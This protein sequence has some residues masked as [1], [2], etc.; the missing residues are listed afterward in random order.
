MDNDEIKIVYSYAN[1]SLRDIANIPKARLQEITNNQL[2]RDLAQYIVE[3]ID[4]LPV[5]YRKKLDVD[6]DSEEHRICINIIS[7]KELKRLRD[8]EED[9][10]RNCYY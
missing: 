3:H 10:I 5:T 4:E 7:D 1:I 9:S 6:L 2:A 8:I